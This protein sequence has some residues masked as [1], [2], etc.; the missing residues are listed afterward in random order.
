MQT[1]DC[2]TRDEAR[3]V[4]TEAREAIGILA[5]RKD[6]IDLIGIG[7]L[8]IVVA[9]LIGTFTILFFILTNENT[10]NLSGLFYFYFLVIILM[11]AI[12]AYLLLYLRFK[13]IDIYKRANKLAKKYNLKKFFNTTLEKDSVID[14]V[15]R[16]IKRLYR[17]L[18][19]HIK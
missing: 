5:L 12:I 19:S 4:K 16:G 6:N 15:I 11:L 9:L 18:R 8:S 2:L 7:I 14:S 3:E 13:S 17:V 1:K 10:P